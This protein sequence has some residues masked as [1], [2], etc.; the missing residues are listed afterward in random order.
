MTLANIRIAGKI[1]IVIAIMAMAAIAISCVGSYGMREL[2]GAARRV[3]TYGSLVR[4]TAVMAL[5]VVNISRGEYR[6]AL[7]PNEIDEI[8]TILAQLKDQLAQRFELLEKELPEKFKP[9][10]KTINDKYNKYIKDADLTFGKAKKAKEVSISE[11][12][13]D[14]YQAVLASRA[15]ATDLINEMT[16]L[17]NLL[18]SEK[19][20]VVKEANK[21]SEQLSLTMVLVAILGIGFGII[22]GYYIAKKGLVNPIAEI[23]EVLHSLTRDELDCEIHGTKRE[24]EVGDIARAALVFR[25]NAKQAE[26]MR[27]K[28]EAKEKAEVERAEKIERLTQEF[29]K[30][31]SGVLEIVAGA[32]TELEAT[33]KSLTSTAEEA[34]QQTATV[35]SATKQASASV[36]T[37]ASAAEELSTA[38]AE[39]AQ[40]VRHSKDAA[41]D[42]SKQ[43]SQTTE[44]MKGLSENSAKIGDVIHLIND[45]AAQ[46]NLLALN[47]TIEAARAGDAGK[48]FAV[49]ANEVKQLASQTA[50]AT[51]EIGTRISSVQG[52]VDQAI[53]AINGVVS[54]IDKVN[55]LTASIA[56]SVEEQSAATNEIARS[57]QQVAAGTQEVTLNIEGV[58]KATSE[59]GAASGQVLS[60]AH[61]LSKESSQLKDVV[62]NFLQDVRSA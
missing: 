61:S 6:A 1:G 15:A 43:A 34:N 45:I 9:N 28:H 54:C 2:T 29:D 58:T 42:A 47:A 50:R 33:A 4:N 21:M 59:T 37:V 46:T 14:L 60:S 16:T 36:Q 20:A 39:I 12:Q 44:V 19:E 26:I 56:S 41:E 57:V 11:G 5:R 51:D 17:N 30:A 53:T 38:I 31:V 62:K 52:A 40:N 27:A 7:A 22:C 3:D 25:D 48:G 24:D 8:L 32:S 35:A 23:I 49:V 10:L 55:E 13:K 18:D